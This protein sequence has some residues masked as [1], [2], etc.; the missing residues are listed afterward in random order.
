MALTVMAVGKVQHFSFSAILQPLCYWLVQ[1]ILPL[2]LSVSSSHLA[3]MSVYLPMYQALT[4]PVSVV[5]LLTE[6]MH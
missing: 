6:N 3:L 5:A 4:I 2:I 1:T